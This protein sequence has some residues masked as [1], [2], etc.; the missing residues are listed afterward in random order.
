MSVVISDVQKH[1]K[2]FSKDISAGDILLEINGNEINDVLDYQFF[3]TEKK[4]KMTL[5]SPDGKT[6]KKTIRKDEYEDIGLLFNTYLMD[7]KQH[8]KNK[9]IF[10]FIDQLPKGMRESLYFKDD[11]SRLSF[12]FGNYIT[13][14]NVTR[15]DID[16]IIK[17]HIS[18]VNISVHTMNPTL[19]VEMMKNPN[20]GECLKYI[21]MLAEA[22]IQ[23]NTQLVLCPGINDGKELR[24]SIEKL[25]SYYPY[26]QSI[27]AVPVGLTKYREGLCRLEAYNEKTA[28]EVID[29][30]EEYSSE[31]LEHIGSRIVFAADEFYLK[32]KR[33]IPDA[34]YYEDFA[35]IEN[36]VGMW[37][38]L[39]K[40]FENAL[41]DSEKKVEKREVYIATGFAAYGLMNYFKGLVESRY[42]DVTVNIIK[43][44]N[45]FFGSSITVVGLITGKDLV[46]NLKGLNKDSD[47]LISSSMLRSEGD[48]F[49]DSMT[50]EEAERISGM[51]IVVTE[52]DG[53]ELL[54]AILGIKE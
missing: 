23:I 3:I 29:I 21:D 19:R 26:V 48:M 42:P 15:H 51:N 2:A 30:I 17:M 52:R 25:M 14:T 5:K 6:Y 20:A 32:A 8:C 44:E 27:A 53:E 38:D 1:S 39:K 49:L 16:R 34:E 43:I 45:K 33:E 40:Q 24:Y 4:L 28:G 47:V 22:G 41:S 36:G 10:C 50:L 35:Q 9:C 46:D 31:Y 37:A 12:L 11:D 18:P 54:N 7:E 13:L